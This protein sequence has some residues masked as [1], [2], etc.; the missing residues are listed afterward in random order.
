MLGLP[1]SF[2]FTLAV[3]AVLYVA[4]A[5]YY[6]FRIV[7]VNAAGDREQWTLRD[8]T[9][10]I[11]IEAPE[12]VDERRRAAGLPPIEWCRAPR[13]NEPTPAIA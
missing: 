10:V 7:A 12:H 2:D 8:G 9:M 1:S 6:Y 5:L 11:G 13:E 3:V 4:V